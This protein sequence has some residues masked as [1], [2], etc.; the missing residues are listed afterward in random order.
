MYG[1]IHIYP[2]RS[3][4]MGYGGYG[5]LESTAYLSTP[6]SQKKESPKESPLSKHG[7]YCL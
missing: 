7:A 1:H 2:L 4:G 5:Y 6:L 3:S